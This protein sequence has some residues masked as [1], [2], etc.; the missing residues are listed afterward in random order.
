MELCIM[1]KKKGV[2]LLYH[3]K[4]VGIKNKGKTIYGNF[5]TP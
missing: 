2:V 5:D 4:E 1:Q 3:T